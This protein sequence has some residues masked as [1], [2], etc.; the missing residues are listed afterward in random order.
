MRGG[1]ECPPH[2]PSPCPLPGIP[3]RGESSLA[4][5]K[6]HAKNKKLNVSSTKARLAGDAIWGRGAWVFVFIQE[7]DVFW[8]SRGG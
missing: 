8:V 2:R 3:G 7:R 6:G 5:S 1:Q 4:A